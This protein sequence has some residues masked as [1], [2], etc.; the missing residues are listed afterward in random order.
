M[1]VEQFGGLRS[2]KQQNPHDLELNPARC[3]RKQATNSLSYGTMLQSNMFCHLD[4]AL[5]HKLRI[6]TNDTHHRSR[7]VIYFDR[8]EMK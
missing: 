2:D 6:V 7:S 1:N 5:S 4:T 3:D 8:R